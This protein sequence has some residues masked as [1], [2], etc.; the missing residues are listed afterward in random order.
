MKKTYV[1]CQ[2]N[3]VKFEVEKGFAQASSEVK[4]YG[5]FANAVNTQEWS[6]NCK[7]NEGFRNNDAKYGSMEVGDWFK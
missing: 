6:M 2:L 7:Q 3:I 5:A 4:T 1:P